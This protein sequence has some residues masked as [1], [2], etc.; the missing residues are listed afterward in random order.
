M[1]M[2]ET[3]KYVPKTEKGCGVFKNVYNLCYQEP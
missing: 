1:M 3:S 2:L